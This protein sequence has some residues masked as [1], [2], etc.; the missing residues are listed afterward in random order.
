MNSIDLTQKKPTAQTSSAPKVEKKVVN[1]S[2]GVVNSAE[3]LN[4]NLKKRPLDVDLQPDEK[5]DK[6]RKVVIDTSSDTSDEDIE[7]DEGFDEDDEDSEDD[8]DDISEIVPSDDEEVIE[9]IPP[10]TEEMIAKAEAERIAA[11]IKGSTHVGGRVLRD[12]T[13]IA[14][15]MENRYGDK[16]RDLLFIKDEKKELLREI[17]IWQMT[18][19]LT[20]KSVDWP[21]LNIRMSLERIRTEHE[22]LRISLG[23]ESTD[24]ETDSEEEQDDEDEDEDDEDDEDDDDDDDD[25]EEEE[26]EENDKENES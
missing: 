19:E 26:E 17:K 11:S 2:I 16:E 20:Q 6:V 15:P 3:S 1:S 12:R 8:E 23:L 7:I 21:V 18:P 22:R 14:N 24:E 9:V 13:K 4:V 5:K 10:E 25:E